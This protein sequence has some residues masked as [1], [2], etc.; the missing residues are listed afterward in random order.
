[1]MYRTIDP[2]LLQLGADGI[3]FGDRP[4]QDRIIV[5]PCLD[6]FDLGYDFGQAVL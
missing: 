1:M 6:A 5:G 2:P 4:V 3:T